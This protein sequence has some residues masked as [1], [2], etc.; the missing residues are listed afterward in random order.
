MYQAAAGLWGNDISLNND[1]QVSY[2]EGAK[3]FCSPSTKSR[4]K[5]WQGWVT[6][7]FFWLCQI[8]RIRFG[9]GQIGIILQNDNAFL[10]GLELREQSSQQCQNGAPARQT[11]SS[12]RS[13]Y[14][15]AHRLGPF[16]GLSSCP[17]LPR[18]K[19]RLR[20]QKSPTTRLPNTVLEA[21]MKVLQKLLYPLSFLW[22]LLPEGMRKIVELSAFSCR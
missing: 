5:Y 11:I 2:V 9:E 19:L 12:W 3:R 8:V 20:R 7:H 16:F 22:S 6:Q 1:A 13:A 18:E 4:T 15:P 10:D 14:H 17:G 21:A